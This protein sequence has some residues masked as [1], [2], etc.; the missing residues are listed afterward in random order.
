MFRDDFIEISRIQN[1]VHGLVC[2]ITKRVGKWAAKMV[3]DWAA[4]KDMKHWSTISLGKGRSGSCPID[5][6]VRLLQCTFCG[7]ALENEWEVAAGAECCKMVP[8]AQHSESTMPLAAFSF[9]S[10]VQ[11]VDDVL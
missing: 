3:G 1:T 9:P 10:P 4:W 2:L 5:I 6:S 11:G 8:E 7:A